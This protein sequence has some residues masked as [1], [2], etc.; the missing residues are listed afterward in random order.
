[1]QTS[2]RNIIGLNDAVIPVHYHPVVLLEHFQQQGLELNELLIN[3][4]IRQDLLEQDNAK[5]SYL[6]LNYLLQQGQILLNNPALGL[7]YGAMLPPSSNG[8]IGMSV[9]AS[10]NISQAITIAL[11]YKK[12]TS[13]ITT[14]SLHHAGRFSY[15]QCSPAMDES[16]FSKIYI[17]TCFSSLYC[18][19]KKMVPEAD[20]NISFEFKF[21]APDYHHEYVKTLNNNIKFNSVKNRIIFD[22]S[23]LNIKLP[24][25]NKQVVHEA[26]QLMDIVQASEDNKMGIIPLVKILL[27][28]VEPSI[29]SLEYLADRLCI[30][31]S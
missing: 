10:E 15:I 31:V 21:S 2:L 19:F 28:E 16:E 12:S 23:V 1:M 11:R 6:Q 9:F 14:L 5:L 26:I 18:F 20:K 29:A 25:P 30:S 17:E 8:L 13:P 3:G 22:S 27:Q 7:H 4:G 24:Y